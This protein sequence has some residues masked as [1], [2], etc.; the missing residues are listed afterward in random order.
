VTSLCCRGN[1]TERRHHVEAERLTYMPFKIPPDLAGDLADTL[2]RIRSSRRARILTLAIAEVPWH[3][4]WPRLLLRLAAGLGSPITGPDRAVLLLTGFRARER[5]TRIVKA[6]VVVLRA[7]HDKDRSSIATAAICSSSTAA[8]RGAAMA[9]QKA[10]L[11]RSSTPRRWG[12][13]PH[14]K[15]HRQRR[16]RYRIPRRHRHPRCPP[17]QRRC[18]I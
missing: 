6:L 7:R 1:A 2:V 15:H 18:P 13:C 5:A 16:C 3:P 14:P 11:G 10:C 17:L 9:R 8:S 4:G 12:R